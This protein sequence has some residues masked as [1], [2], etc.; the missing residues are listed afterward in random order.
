MLSSTSRIDP[1]AGEAGLAPR[2]AVERADAHQAVHA[3]FGF[4]PAV[5]V[6]TLDLEGAALD[7]S[8]FTGALLQPAHL[9]AAPLGPARVHARQHLGPVLRL[10]AT[11]A[12]VDLDIGVVGVG[13]AGQQ[14][15]EPGGTRLGAGLAQGGL[16]VG[17]HRLVLLG[18]GHLDQPDVVVNRGAQAPDGSDRRLEPGA[19]LHHRLGLLLVVPQRR[20][21]GARVQLVETNDRTV[22]VKDAS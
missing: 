9:E 18:L 7:A 10:G 8:L 16:G 13:L 11:G 20:I 22:V 15:L 2:V 6:A 21:L 3:R 19:L 14:R 17:D 5:G 1:D 12:G 4:Q